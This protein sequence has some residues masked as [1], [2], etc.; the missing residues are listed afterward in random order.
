MTNQSFEEIY[1][2]GLIKEIFGDNVNS[3]RVTSEEGGFFQSARRAASRFTNLFTA[4]DIRKFTKA[5]L[6]SSYNVVEH[7]G[8]VEKIS[9][10]PYIDY[11]PVSNLKVNL[12]KI[13]LIPVALA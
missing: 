10:T 11:L 12:L 13:S 5:E 8:V 9:F 4:R 7:D 6:S 1:Y 3:N 2:Y